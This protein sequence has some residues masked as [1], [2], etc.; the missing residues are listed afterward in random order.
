MVADLASSSLN[1]PSFQTNS[2]R[3]S[4]GRPGIPGLHALRQ[5]ARRRRH[6]SVR[7]VCKRGR[8]PETLLIPPPVSPRSVGLNCL[9]ADSVVPTVTPGRA[10]RAAMSSATE[11]GELTGW[12]FRNVEAATLRVVLVVQPVARAASP[13]TPM[14][15]WSFRRLWQAASSSHSPRAPSS[16]RSSSCLAFCRVLI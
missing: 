16:P 12:G 14:T 5:H 2:Q 6:R 3:C 1:S 8:G 11:S 13:L 15:P 7:G 9:F 4:V 10:Y